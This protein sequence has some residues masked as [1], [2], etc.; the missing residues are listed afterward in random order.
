MQAKLHYT[1]RSI[2]EVEA[3]LLM[4]ARDRVYAITTFDSPDDPFDEIDV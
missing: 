4:I 1:T 2:D 3:K